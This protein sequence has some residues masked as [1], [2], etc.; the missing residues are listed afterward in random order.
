[1]P[2]VL[3]EQI[4]SLLREFFDWLGSEIYDIAQKL[5]LIETDV[6]D[7]KTDVADIKLDVNAIS[8]DVDSIDSKMTTANGYL[9]DIKTNTGAVV[10]PVS[11]IK[12]GVDVINANVASIEENVDNIEGFMS[13]IA[14]NTGTAAT[15]DEEIATNTLNCYNKLVTIA[16]DTTQL[17]ADNVQIIQLL[18]QLVQNTTPTP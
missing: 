18:Q 12:V 6:S 16:S 10:T 15:Y 4:L 8:A 17:R 13:T 9:S 11:Q 1:M 7:I 5:D 3:L 14:T 2:T